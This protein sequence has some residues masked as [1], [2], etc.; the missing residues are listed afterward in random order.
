MECF[1]GQICQA[2]WYFA[3]RQIV[4]TGVNITAYEQPL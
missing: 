3:V 1:A 2:G 4:G